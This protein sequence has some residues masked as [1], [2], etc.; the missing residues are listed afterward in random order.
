MPLSKPL[1]R[2]YEEQAQR[3]YTLYRQLRDEGA[4]LDWAVTLLFYSALHLINVVLIETGTAFDL[5]RD[6]GDRNVA[7]ALKLRPVYEDY[8]LLYRL[9]R[10]ARYSPERPKPTP[11]LLQR[12]EGEPFARILAELQQYGVGLTL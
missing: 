12:Y 7:I 6:H 8:R 2:T 5:P 10:T 3:N 4:H 1:A 9:S 11:A